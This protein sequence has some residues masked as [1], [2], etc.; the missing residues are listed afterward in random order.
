MGGVSHH[1]ERAFEAYLTRSK[2]PHVLVDDVKRAVLPAGAKL[3]CGSV[4][5][6]DVKIKSFDAVVYGDH[7]ENGRHLLVEV[8][9]R[10]VD[11]RKGGCGRRESWTTADDVASLRVW[12]RL[13]G[14][15]FEGVLLFLYWLEGPSVN[16]MERETFRFEGRVYAHRAVR[17]REYMQ[18]M[19]VRSPRWGTV[20]L[21]SDDFDAVSEPLAG[22]LR[23]GAGSVACGAPVA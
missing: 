17:L 14:E 11:L 3:S 13:F 10:R 5:G 4:S 7:A 23:S 8:K 1:Y 16:A 22:L 21:G 6:A 19:R 20:N 15:P 18:R 2:I 12:E 9:G